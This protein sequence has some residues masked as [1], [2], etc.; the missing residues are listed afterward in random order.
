MCLRI[1]LSP[2]RPGRDND[3]RQKR[4]DTKILALRLA[5]LAEQVRNGGRLS[6][7]SL[8]SHVPEAKRAVNEKWGDGKRGQQDQTGTGTQTFMPQLHGQD[9]NCQPKN[10]DETQLSAGAGKRCQHTLLERRRA[11]PENLLGQPTV[12]SP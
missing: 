7:E 11:G 1:L 2:I 3:I 4:Q 8:I 12:Q 9:S 10:A 5:L 6:V